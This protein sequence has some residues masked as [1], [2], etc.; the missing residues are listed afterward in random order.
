MAKIVDE[1]SCQIGIY[2]PRDIAL[3]H[4]ET[5][6]GP[7]MVP[8][9]FESTGAVCTAQPRSDRFE[10]CWRQIFLNISKSEPR[11]D[12]AVLW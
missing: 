4:G 9:A 3:G 10:R 2:K 11:I 7:Q 1:N 8:V 6:N 12:D 5:G